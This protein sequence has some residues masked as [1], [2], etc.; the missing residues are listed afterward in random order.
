MGD[1]APR[2]RFYGASS[3]LCQNTA[4]QVMR[5]TMDP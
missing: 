1:S 4:W 5:K 2:G 3:T